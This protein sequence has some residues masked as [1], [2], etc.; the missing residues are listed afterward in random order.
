M[1]KLKQKMIE[2][3][4]RILS[5]TQDTMMFGTFHSEL[6]FTSAVVNQML[7]EGIRISPEHSQYITETMEGLFNVS[8]NSEGS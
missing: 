6:S 4:D 1:G 8:D 3:Q 7:K 5:I 2:E